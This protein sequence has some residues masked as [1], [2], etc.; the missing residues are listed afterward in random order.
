MES[1]F[2]GYTD[3]EQPPVNFS[4]KINRFSEKQNRDASGML[5]KASCGVFE[6]VAVDVCES[7]IRRLSPKSNTTMIAVST[8]ARNAGRMEVC[9]HRPQKSTLH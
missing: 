1:D 9:G 2:S 4:E 8:R 7:T 5:W 3:T 6:D